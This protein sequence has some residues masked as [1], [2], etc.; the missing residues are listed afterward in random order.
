MDI[1][2]GSIIIMS[3]LLTTIL[4]SQRIVAQ[5]TNYTPANNIMLLSVS[6][7]ITPVKSK[8]TKVLIE[9]HSL[10]L[11]KTN[12]NSIANA[13]LA[14]K[15]I[16]G[17]VLKSKCIFSFNTIVGPRNKSKGFLWA[18]LITGF[19]WGGGVC[20]AS[21]VLYQAARDAGLEIIERNNHTKIV[22]YAKPGDDAMVSYGT[23]DNRFKNNN[24]DIQIN[25]SLGSDCIA[26]VQ[27][28][29]LVYEKI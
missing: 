29:K 21:T 18:P 11:P 6:K 3:L 22:P 2:V 16:N 19:G 4:S 7:P 15:F 5:E 26:H 9:N 23:S 25:C 1:K 28:Y 10:K 20:K 24:F 13:R 8:Y 17:Y 14:L 27:I 12:M